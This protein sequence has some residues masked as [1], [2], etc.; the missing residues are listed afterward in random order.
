MLIDIR[1]RGKDGERERN[2]CVKKNVDLLPFACSL[3]RAKPTTQVCTLTGNQTCDLLVHGMISN[4]L[5]RT[6]Q[7][8]LF[9]FVLFFIDSKGCLIRHQNLYLSSFF[10]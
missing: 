5:S 8:S 9:L 4:Q 3:T 6:G 7:G 2:I 1:E 10:S